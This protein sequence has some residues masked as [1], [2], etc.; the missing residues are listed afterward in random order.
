MGNLTFLKINRLPLF[1]EIPHRWG[2]VLQPAD[3]HLYPWL[4]LIA[5][6]VLGKSLTVI[7]NLHSHL[8]ALWLLREDLSSQV[9]S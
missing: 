5:D 6:H 8:E 1:D 4:L 2:T 7:Q 9:R 3:D